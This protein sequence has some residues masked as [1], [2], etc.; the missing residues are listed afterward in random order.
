M[1]C[2]EQIRCNTHSVCGLRPSPVNRVGKSQ[3]R[4]HGFFGLGSIRGSGHNHFAMP[5]LMAFWHFVALEH[6]VTITV[7]CLEHG[8]KVSVELILADAAVLI[9]VKSCKSPR[10]VAQQLILAESVVLVGVKFQRIDLAVIAKPLVSGKAGSCR[11]ADY[12][13]TRNKKELTIVAGLLFFM[14]NPD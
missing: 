5:T 3:S 8:D 4:G 13:S 11:K 1:T 2:S 9:A 14:G 7:H 12:K 10:I 6:A